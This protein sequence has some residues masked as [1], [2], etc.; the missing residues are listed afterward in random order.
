MLEY[1]EH[2]IP[3]ISAESS[4]QKPYDRRPDR[5]KNSSLHGDGSRCGGANLSDP[6]QIESSMARE[7]GRRI[8]FQRDELSENR[9][10]QLV[11][12]W[13]QR[14]LDP[15]RAAFRAHYRTLMR[16]KEL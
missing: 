16:Q 12:K 7:E 4:Q 3:A 2:R 5:D 8:R 14:T 15:G 10:V 11:S 13:N 1:G 6:G 9:D